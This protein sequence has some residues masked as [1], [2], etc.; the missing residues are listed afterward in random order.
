MDGLP[1]QTEPVNPPLQGFEQA[2]GAYEAKLERLREAAV[3]WGVRPY[4]PEGAFIGAM[5][6]AIAELGTMAL[7]IGARLEATVYRGEI[8]VEK[9][10]RVAESEVKGLQLAL[11]ESARLL[12]DAKQALTKI[13]ADREQLIR[14]A[15]STMSKDITTSLQ[16]PMMVR[17]TNLNTE[18]LWI[19]YMMAGV[20]GIGILLTGLIMGEVDA[21]KPGMTELAIRQC[22]ENPVTDGKGT[23]Y[24]Q[25]NRLQAGLH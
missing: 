2:Q 7:S 15:V 18:R 12:S 8:A 22:A 19:R 6:G 13:G 1:K 24:C 9:R 14:E 17:A 4:T 11:H 5:I 20:A 16:R 23:A 3:E 25:L 21:A 10:V